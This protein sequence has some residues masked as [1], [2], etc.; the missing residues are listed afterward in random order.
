MKKLFIVALLALGL[1]A[2]AQEAKRTWSEKKIETTYGALSLTEDQKKQMLPLFDEQEKLYKEIKTNP[3]TKD[4]N[5]AQIKEIGKKL[6]AI[7][8]PEQ[9]A[10]L[11]EIKAAKKQEGKQE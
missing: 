3:D 6:N 1:N 10:R 9:A 7:L 4:A 5:R 11:K 2:S 8:T